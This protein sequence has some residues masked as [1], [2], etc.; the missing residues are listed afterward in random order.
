M[1]HLI[2]RNL[3]AP[4]VLWLILVPAIVLLALYAYRRPRRERPMRRAASAL[5]AVLLGIGLF[6]CLGPALREDQVKV[7]PAP[8]AIL[9]D[10]SASMLQE[11]GS[12]GVSRLQRVQATLQNEFSS[13]L[14]DRY[15]V[16]SWRFGSRLQATA[17][18]GSDLKG[19]AQQTALGEALMAVLAENRGRRLPD[20][21]LF[22]DGRSNEGQELAP[23]AERLRAEGVEVHVLAVGNSEEAP[24]LML[25]RVQ[26][27]DLVLSG[28]VSLFSLRLRGEGEDLPQTAVVRLLDETGQELDR[29]EV[30]R[31]D[32]NGVNVVLSALLERAGERRLVAEV[33]PA[34]G[35]TALDNNRLDLALTVK[36]VKVRV[37]L[38]EGDP[39]YEYRFLKDRLL[40]SERD[41][42]LNCW[43][44]SADRAFPQE[45]S[46]S[47]GPLLRLPLDADELLENFDLII[48]GDVDPTELTA[49]ALDGQRFLKSVATF[50]ERGGG[51]LM[52][53]GPQANPSAYLGSPLEALLPVV[54]GNQRPRTDTSFTPIPADPLRPNPVVLFSSDPEE[55]L[56]LWN[57]SA[58][59]WWYRPVQ[60]LRPG[61]QAWLVHPESSNEFGPEVIAAG[62]FSPE[63]WVGWIGTDE[64]WRWRFPGG[65]KYV[66]RF[67]RSALRQLAST[68]LKGDRGRVRLDLD[69]S[70]VELGEFLLVEARLLDDSF[71][72][73]QGDEELPLFSEGEE[74]L[75]LAAIPDQPGVYRGRLRATT[76]GSTLIYLTEDG[77]GDS[78]PLVSAR[79]HVHLPSR[80]MVRTSLDRAALDGLTERTGGLL[81]MLPDAGE[82]LDELDGKEQ[83]TRIL[84]SSMHELPVWPWIL[85]FLVVGAS[86]WLLRKRLNLS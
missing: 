73:V 7:E 76:L 26:S 53:A 13:V 29:V 75:S 81:L 21:L 70:E 47:S 30:Q 62:M 11:D 28:D 61:A 44:A 4:W 74:I 12:D 63:G 58:P 43:L 50:V 32:A 52:L 23:V 45:H 36:S 42:V 48:I 72:P 22:S 34:Q 57:D 54:L 24:D 55:N 38:V 40:R 49:D 56:A 46:A 20:I 86:E 35:E 67:W 1:S 16:Q 85:A 77:R 71:V 39:R 41:V 2:F 80:E 9:L 5:R 8:L 69:R 66:D 78:E 33:L 31:P 68:R 10:D 27:P 3:P 17:T 6:L 37:L 64:T 25:E 84:E 18:D 15:Q 82:M 60:R 59:L 14:E 83:V 79:F 65:E 19:E 51:L